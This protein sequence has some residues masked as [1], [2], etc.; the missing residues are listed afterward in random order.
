MEFLKCNNIWERGRV[1]GNCMKESQILSYDR[2]IIEMTK[3]MYLLLSKDPL[4]IDMWWMILIHI[5]S[6]ELS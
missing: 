3:N 4:W 2:S 6:E 5:A 1:K